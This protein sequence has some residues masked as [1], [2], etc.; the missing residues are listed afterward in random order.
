[1]ETLY[2]KALGLG[3][4]GFDPSGALIAMALLAAGAT[5]RAVLF[6]CLTYLLALIALLTLA[7]SILSTKLPGTSWRALDTHP[8]TKAGAEI[9]IGLLLLVFAAWR[10]IHAGDPKPETPRKLP[11]STWATV[12][13][14]GL[15]AL[16]VVGDPALLAFAVVAGT[17]NT[18]ADIIVAQTIAVL[19]SKMLVVVVMVGILSG[20]ERA[21]V[22][23]LTKWWKRAA[24]AMGKVVTIVLIAMAVLLMTNAIWWFRTDTFLL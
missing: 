24:P 7:S 9:T 1:M 16:G 10:L 21:F 14:G 17:A 18:L 5:R 23:R 22:E 15:L 11:V 20:H 6:F 13:L 2:L 8:G 12:G 4:A 19:A 3:I